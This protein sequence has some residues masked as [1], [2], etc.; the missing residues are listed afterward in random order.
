MFLIDGPKVIDGSTMIPYVVPAV[1]LLRM[2][3]ELQLKLTFEAF[4]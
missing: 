4:M 3:K 1:P 2:R